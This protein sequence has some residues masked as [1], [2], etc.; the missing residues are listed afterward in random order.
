MMK[1]LI[2]KFLT[3]EMFNYILFGVLTTIVN[4]GIYEISVYLGADYK[5]ATV[6]AWIAAVGF[7]FITNKVF[8]FGSRSFKMKIFLKELFSFVLARIVSGIVDLLFMILA[9]E[10]IHMNDSLAKLVSNVFVMVINYILSKFIIFN[11][12]KGDFYARTK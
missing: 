11:K 3:R 4:Y 9:V 2:K 10:I 1:K 8:V 6:L 12:N 7:A 5:L